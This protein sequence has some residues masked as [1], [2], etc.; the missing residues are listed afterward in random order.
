[1]N[2]QQN[3]KKERIMPELTGKPMTRPSIPLC[4]GDE[5][6]NFM[7]LSEKTVYCTRCAAH[8]KFVKE[9]KK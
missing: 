7:P 8:V 6:H 4:I 5:A 9:E 1:L 2:Y 3:D